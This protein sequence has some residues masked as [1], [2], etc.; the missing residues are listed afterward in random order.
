MDEETEEEDEPDPST[1]DREREPSSTEDATPAFQ[2]AP[3]PSTGG[4]GLFAI[5]PVSQGTIVFSERPLF[6]QPSG[7]RRTNSTV[8]AALAERTR[9]EQRQFFTL[10]NA[11]KAPRPGRLVLLPA[12]G[13]FETNALPCGVA[14]PPYGD[15]AIEVETA[16][17]TRKDARVGVFLQAS[18]FNHSCRPN[19]SRYWDSDT[20]E[21][22]FRAIRDVQAGDELC[23]SYIDVDVL[24]TRAQR[25]AGIEPAFRFT[26]VCEACTLKGEEAQVSDRRRTSLKRLYEEIGKCGKEPTLGLRKVS[27]RAYTR[28]PVWL[29]NMNR[30]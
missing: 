22:V 13:I 17:K 26:C 9:D 4:V 16:E 27:I 2:I 14:L 24:A 15:R 20:Q 11:Y 5:R 25:V 12:L 21:M 1:P 3:S 7:S 19:V 30:V 28:I 29:L 10:W 18:R 6:T 8:M 23:L